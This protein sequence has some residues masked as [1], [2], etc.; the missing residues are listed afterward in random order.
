MNERPVTE[1][2]HLEHFISKH[3]NFAKISYIMTVSC[4]NILKKILVSSKYFMRLFPNESR[5]VCVYPYACVYVY[6]SHFHNHK[7]V[8]K[9]IS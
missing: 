5:L 1:R 3:G 6:K 9:L 4:E 8:L 7:Q 2:L